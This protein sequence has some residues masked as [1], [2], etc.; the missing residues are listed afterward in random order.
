[1]GLSSSQARLLSITARLT[2]NE[3]RTQ[4]LTNARLKLTDI[5]DAARVQYQNALNS[6]KF[7]YMS[8]N[9]NGS[10]VKI[11]LTP[12]VL[13]QYQPCKN[14]YSLVNN[15]NKILVSS[16]DAKNFKET[17][18]LAEFLKRYG[19][20]EEIKSI[21]TF[22]KAAGATDENQENNNIVK[23]I[24][25]ETLKV[26]DPE[27]AQ[28]Y[29]NL[30]YRMNGMDDP[31]R[32]Y[33]QTGDN[34][35]ANNEEITNTEYLLTLY[36][37][38]K[39]TN[40]N[41]YEELDSRLMTSKDWL[42][43]ALAQGIVTMEKVGVG[44]NTS[45]DKFQWSSIIYTNATDIISQQD[46]TKI[47]QAE[48]EYNQAMSEVNAKDKVFENKIRKLDTEHNALQTEYNS[49]KAAMDKNIERSFK[50]FQG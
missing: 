6:N 30:W 27:K 34:V 9:E 46:D 15:A 23:S 43:N 20:F 21:K 26:T 10:G 42:N 49:V 12:T 41:F 35:N 45:E 38:K 14:Q 4:S 5:S 1:M 19:C 22:I 3:Y 24:T 29:T 37:V 8:Y 48:A 36:D 16:T 18:N 11:D 39:Q 32:I 28:W 44:R 2:D 31:E 40:F 25:E 47:A 7:V 13:Y 33:K 50:V 17:D